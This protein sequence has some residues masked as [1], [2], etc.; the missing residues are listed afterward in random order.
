MV[1][2]GQKSHGAGSELNSVLDKVDRWN[3]I[4]TP[5]IQFRSRLMRFLGFSNREK[6]AP[7]R[8]ISK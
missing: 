4:R 7:R 8:E 1:G 5:A 6:G 3:P 2:K